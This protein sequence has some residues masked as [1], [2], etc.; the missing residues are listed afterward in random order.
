MIVNFV[1]YLNLFSSLSQ[2]YS[3]NSKGDTSYETNYEGVTKEL[4]NLS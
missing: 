3:E 2:K 4:H 1:C